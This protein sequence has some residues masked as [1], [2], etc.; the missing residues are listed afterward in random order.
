MA[1]LWDSTFHLGVTTEALQLGLLD[2][3]VIALLMMQWKSDAFSP[4]SR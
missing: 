2:A 3:A 4:A 1:N